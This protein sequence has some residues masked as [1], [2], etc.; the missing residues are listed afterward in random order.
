MKNELLRLLIMVAKRTFYGFLTLLVSLSVLIASDGNAQYESIKDINVSVRLQN[1]SLGEALEAIESSTDFSFTFEEKELLSRKGISVKAKE[2]SLD[3]ILLKISRDANVEFLQV[4][5]NIHVKAKPAKKAPTVVAFEQA[6][7]ITGT[8]LS[9]EDNTGLPGVNVIIKGTSTGTVTDIEG[10]YSIDVPGEGAVLVFS[11]VGFVTEEA[12]VGNQSIINF[13]LKADITALQE[14]V[15]VGY[16]TQQKVNLTGAVGVAGGEVLENRPIANVGEGLQG[17]IPNLNV[18]IRNGDPATPITFDIR[19]YGSINGGSPLILVDGVPMDLNRLNPNDIESVSV[20]KDA[21]AA[22]VYGARAAF[23]V[24]LVTT[25]KG[26]GDK[27]N[28]SFGSEFAAAKPIFL[29]DPVTD[30]YQFVLARN[31]A[32]MRT[33]GAVSFDQDYIDGTQRWSENP[34]FENKWGVYNNQLRLYG[35]N[36]YVDDLITE[37]AP[38]QKYD[39]SVSGSTEKAN[40]Y[41]SFGHLNKDGYLKDKENNENFKRYNFLL[42]GEFKANEWLSLDTRALIST[43]VS[44]KPHFYNWDVNI[45]TSARVSPIQAIQFPDLPYY[46]T[47]GDRDQYQQYIGMYFG[48][49]NFFPYLE[50]GGRSTWTKSDVV[51][52]QGITLTPAKGLTINGDFNY[53]FGNLNYQDVQ[54]KVNIIE[55]ADLTNLIIGNGFS[56][57]DWI[58]NRNNIDQYYVVNL[59]ADYTRTTNNGHFI[60]G[61]IGFNQEWGNYQ[62]V[63][64]RAYR[65][66]TP[67]VPDLNTTT[68]AQETS[69]GKSHVALRGVFYRLNYIYKDRYLFEANGR[70]DGTSRFPKENRFGFFPSFAAGWR[71][72]NESFMSGTSGWLDNLKI[73]ASYGEL[74]N[75]ILGG[76]GFY[77]YIATMPSGQSQHMMSAG[78]RTPFVGPPN[79]V[80]PTLTWE[81]VI[82]RNLGLDLTVLNNRLDLS[83]DVYTRDTKD[84]LSLDSFLPAIAGVNPPLENAADLRTRGWELAATWKTRVNNNFRYDVTLALADNVAEITKFNNPTGSLGNRYVGQIIGERWGFITEGIFQTADEVANHADQSQ[85]G[86]NW[87][88]GDIKYKDLNGDGRITRG[89]NTLDD[90]GDREIIAYEAPRYTYGINS[91]IGWKDFSL[92]IFFQGVM[93]Q[94]FWPP[95]D[96]WNA[97]YPYNAGHVENYYLTDT[98]SEDNPDAYFPAPHISTNTKQNVEPQ[99]RYVQNG[100]YIR[101]KNLSLAY[102]LPTALTTKLHIVNAQIYFAG[103]NLW[104]ATRMRR[105]LDPEIRPTLTQ[106]YYKQRVYSLGL[107]FTF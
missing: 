91:N 42:K 34:T 22:A 72:S 88:P 1:A 27:I 102:N 2:Q 26:K 32:N 17:V 10:N 71:I 85:L 11:S 94:D 89:N 24:V 74:G 92:N 81:T 76:A 96:N 63:R 55:N 48:G 54:S 52:T 64:A 7:N 13:T 19:G 25:K 39:L 105:P 67:T 80:S 49:T 43:E 58:E 86:P 30:P 38:Q 87:R 106:E 84:M 51:L 18:N 57:N 60:Q 99:S 47:P 8:V 69:G 73:R 83:F 21:S 46:L 40:Y 65:L 75:Q 68:G 61:M 50:D 93:K 101:L 31:E 3:M 100:A 90:P 66:I 4:N 59:F 78:Q 56:G 53:N 44:N 15:V 28:V 14:I 12:V 23:G 70:Y 103:M 95:N 104:E 45:N 41:M 6:R 98:W 36:N 82:S 29:I 33:N 16:G 62:V 35:Y 79:L 107:R 37:F 97:F 5:N 20:L 9:S 77:P